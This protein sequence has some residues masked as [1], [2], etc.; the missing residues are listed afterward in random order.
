MKRRIAAL[1]PAEPGWKVVSYL[2]EGDELELRVHSVAGWALEGVHLGP[3][4]VRMN[5]LPVSLS[6]AVLS[7]LPGFVGIVAPDEDLDRRLSSFMDMLRRASEAE[8]DGAP[9]P[10]EAVSSA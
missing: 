4:H 8:D 6:G 7:D 2:G 5:G 1:L 9:A 10:A 3:P